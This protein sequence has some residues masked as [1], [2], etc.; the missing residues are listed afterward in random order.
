MKDAFRLSA[1]VA[2]HHLGQMIFYTSLFAV[3]GRWIIAL[4][5]SRFFIKLFLNRIGTHSGSY[6]NQYLCMALQTEIPAVIKYK[7]A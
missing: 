1:I 2:N 4:F 6:L 5:C 7:Q 3:I